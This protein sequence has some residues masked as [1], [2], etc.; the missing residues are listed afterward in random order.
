MKL[1]AA[2][3]VLVKLMACM[4]DCAPMA[5]DGKVRLLGDTVT[6]MVG[7]DA[8]VPVRVTDWG[9]LAALSANLTVAD[10]APAAAGLKRT[11]TVQEAFTASDVPQ[12]LV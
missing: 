3:P 5:V 2:A 10:I 7:A 8:P 9:E 6:E 11:V 1:S 4:A 12:L